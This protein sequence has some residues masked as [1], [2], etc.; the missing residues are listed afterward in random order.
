M[1]YIRRMVDCVNNFPLGFLLKEYQVSPVTLLVML[2]GLFFSFSAISFK[3][4]L[5]NIQSRYFGTRK[6]KNIRCLLTSLQHLE[7]VTNSLFFF[8]YLLVSTTQTSAVKV[9]NPGTV[10]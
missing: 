10:K 2:T 8:F 7:S 6:V 5:E 9:Q 3:L 1:R 4:C